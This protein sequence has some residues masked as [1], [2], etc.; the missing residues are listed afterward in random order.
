[1]LVFP[2]DVGLA[3]EEPAIDTLLN[4]FNVSAYPTLIV[5]DEKYEGVTSPTE[6]KEII[7]SHLENEAAC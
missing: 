3:S 7:C 1:M 2:I 5:E 6:L 4:R